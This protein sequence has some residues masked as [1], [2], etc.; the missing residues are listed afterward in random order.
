MTVAGSPVSGEHHDLCPWGV[1]LTPIRESHRGRLA[2][3]ADAE[4]HQIG[5]RLGGPSRVPART[6]R[7]RV[8]NAGAP[9]EL[10]GCYRPRVRPT[11]SLGR[12]WV[13]R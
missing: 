9:A 1:S 8:L 13:D 6:K 4:Q 2:D 11:Q 5:F 3:H 7:L 12:N 10:A